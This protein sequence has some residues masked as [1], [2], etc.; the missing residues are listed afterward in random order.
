MDMIFLKPI[1]L[2]KDLK[3]KLTKNRKLKITM[4]ARLDHIKDHETLIKAFL[5]IK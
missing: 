4:V 1:S 5:S 3:D 2:E